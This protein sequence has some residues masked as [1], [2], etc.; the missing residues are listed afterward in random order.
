M[1]RVDRPGH[2]MVVS[3]E[4]ISGYM[5]AM[6]MPFSVRNS[7]ELDNLAPGTM[8]EFTL[9]VDKKSSH[10]EN[11]KVRTFEDFAQ[12]PSQ[13]RRLNLLQKILEPDLAAAELTLGQPVPDF[14][15]TDQSQRSVSLH[16][17]AGKVV[18]LNFVYTRCRLPDY[19]YRFSNNFGRLQ[20][21][22]ADRFGRD[23]VLLT[24][25]FDPVHDQ[26]EILAAY[27]RTWKANPD[28][29]RFLTGPTDDIR[30]VCSWFGVEFWSDEAQFTHTQHT[31]V[32]DRKGKLVANIEGNQYT[33]EQ[34]GDLLE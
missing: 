34:L 16:E 10:A 9:V 29:W 31:V 8:I 20:K 25:T 27:A 32:I 15:L 19:C 30:R 17:F 6:A 4:A 13:A 1:L 5:E 18:G 28:A 7:R 11:V 14:T 23:L 22:F 33:A 3:C 21:R 24:I 26:P 2:T 12:E